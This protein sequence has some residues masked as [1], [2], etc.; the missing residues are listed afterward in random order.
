ME[1][2][3]DLC[4]L[5]ESKARSPITKYMVNSPSKEVMVEMTGIQ[6]LCRA[7]KTAFSYRSNTLDM[8]AYKIAPGYNGPFLDYVW[9]SYPDDIHIEANGIP[10]V[11]TLIAPP[12]SSVDFEALMNYKGVKKVSADPRY[13]EWMNYGMYVYL[14]YEDIMEEVNSNSF[15]AT[16]K[17][18]ILSKHEVLEETAAKIID[19]GKIRH[20]KVMG[21]V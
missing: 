8:L 2:I 6:N 9:S 3:C 5:E 15:R 19:S 1:D 10:R 7:C 17:E 21:K 20:D 4:K 14:K 12:N 16:L 11:D 13:E 18:V